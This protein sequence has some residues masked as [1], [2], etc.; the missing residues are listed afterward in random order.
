MEIGRQ[1][2]MLYRAGISFYSGK[3]NNLDFGAGQMSIIF[4]LFHHQGASQDEL[5]KQLEVDKATI[6]RSV[7]KLESAGILERKKD[8]QDQRINR[9]TLTEAG[10]AIQSDLKKLTDQWQSILLKDFSDG[11][12]EQLMPLFEKLL[13]NVRDFK[14]ATCKHERK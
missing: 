2:S 6:T 4:Y 10:Y 1:I 14:H 3:S 7:K 5:T 8:E 12:L 9:I 11:E 13:K